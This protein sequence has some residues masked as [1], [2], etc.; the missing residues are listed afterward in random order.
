MTELI[1]LR[2]LTCG[3]RRLRPGERFTASD[4]YAR[5][6]VATGHAR[7]APELAAVPLAAGEPPAAEA[8]PP[9]VDEA[10][11]AARPRRTYKRRDMRPED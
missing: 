7:R 11:V 1:A 9:P 10:P 5:L 6:M 8:P 2:P 3:P 4:A